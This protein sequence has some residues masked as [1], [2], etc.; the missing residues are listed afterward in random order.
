MTEKLKDTRFWKELATA[1]LPSGSSK[2]SAVAIERIL[3]KRTKQ[4]E[5]RFSQWEGTKLM[6]RA[7]DLPEEE[8]LPLVSA[9]IKNGV[10]SEEFVVGLRRVL[11]ELA[12][13]PP[14]GL[15][16]DSPELVRVQAHFHTLIRSRAASA[17]EIKAERCRRSWRMPVPRTNQSGSPSKGCTADSSIGG[18]QRRSACDS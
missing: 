13:P 8:L 9:A 15:P 6:P 14:E 16:P 11:S 17:S 2:K 5:I 7:L 3:V 12:P 18:T 4:I 10:F 1:K